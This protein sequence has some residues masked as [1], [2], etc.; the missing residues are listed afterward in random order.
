MWARNLL[1]AGAAAYA[2]SRLVDWMSRV[3]ITWLMTR[4]MLLTLKERAERP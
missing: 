3:P 2:L 1:I 4:K